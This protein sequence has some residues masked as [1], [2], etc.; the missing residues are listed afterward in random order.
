MVINMERSTVK[1]VLYDLLKCTNEGMKFDWSQLQ[2]DP[3]TIKVALE[4][5]ISYCNIAAIFYGD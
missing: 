2:Q 1:T 5:A 3:W 4:N